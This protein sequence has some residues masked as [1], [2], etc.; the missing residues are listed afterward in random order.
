MITP[1]QAQAL[2][3]AGAITPDQFAQIVAAPPGAAPVSAPATVAT[4]P[5]PS[6]AQIASLRRG[7]P[8]PI[9]VGMPAAAPAAPPVAAPPAPIPGWLQPQLSAAGLQGPQQQAPPP[10]TAAPAAGQPGASGTGAPAATELRDA[11]QAR[12]LAPTGGSAARPLGLSPAD[13]AEVGNIE[14]QQADETRLTDDILRRHQQSVD[15]FADQSAALADDAQVGKLLFQQSEQENAKHRAAL[16]QE[17]QA[18]HAKIQAKLT[19]LDSQGIDPNGFFHKAGT[20]GSILAAIGLGLGAYGSGP[21]GAHGVETTNTALD[22]IKGAIAQDIDAQKAD[23]AHHI[24][25]TKLSGA[26]LSENYDHQS[27]L[28]KAERES[29]LSAY[30]VAMNEVQKR[31]EMYKDNADIQAKSAALQAGLGKG[32]LEDVGQ[33]NEQ[34]YKLRKGAERLV[35]GGGGGPTRETILAEGRRLRTQ[36]AANGKDISVDEA[37]RQAAASYGVNLYTSGERPESIAKE[38]SGKP[39]AKAQDQINAYDDTIAGLKDLINLRKQNNG[40]TLNPTARDTAKT[41]AAL[42]QERLVASKGRMNAQLFKRTEEAIPNNPAAYSDYAGAF[43]D[44]YSARMQTAVDELQKERDRMVSSA[45]SSA[46]EHD[47]S[48]PAGLERE[49]EEP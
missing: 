22:I 42:L 13:K 43:G 18:A 33:Q 21:A 41:K 25:V 36:A 26:N 19:E 38:R 44:N 28:L 15:A 24:E 45:P 4:G 31:A 5:G 3:D 35:G 39:S 14:T 46:P 1:N 11:I 17:T 48:N 23:L 34:L 40:G 9:Q 29:T 20:G 30:S 8:P 7:L 27:A 10:L 6:D 49:D 32:M 12:M 16:D 37:N 47:A 2:L